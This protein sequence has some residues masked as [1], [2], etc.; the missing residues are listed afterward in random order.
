MFR[1]AMVWFDGCRQVV[2]FNSREAAARHKAW[3]ARNASMFK[4]RAIAYCQDAR[5]RFVSLAMGV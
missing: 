1:I 2:A 3:M 5:G 4:P